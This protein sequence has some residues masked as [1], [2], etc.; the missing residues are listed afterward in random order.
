MKVILLRDIKS[1]GRKYEV[2]EVNDGFARNGLIGKS[3]ALPATPENLGRLKGE[4]AKVTQTAEIRANLLGK[5]LS[6]VEGLLLEFTAK[7]G[8]AGHLFADIH[9]S[10]IA[11]ELA[12]KTGLDIHPDWLDV[13]AI[14]MVGEHQITLKIGNQKAIFKVI[15]KN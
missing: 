10:T 6:A 12:Q 8:P 3:W 2:K 13:K 11:A 5:G 1:V 4:M 9:A 14:K 7:A 15:V